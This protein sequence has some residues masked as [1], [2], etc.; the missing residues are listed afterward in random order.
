M[1][2]YESLQYEV[3]LEKDGFQIRKYKQF[4]TTAVKENTLRANN[5]FGI[6]F[7]YIS[8]NNKKRQ[9][10][11][12]TVPVISELDKDD[13]TMEFV[14]PAKFSKEQIPQPNDPSVKI[15]SYPEHTALVLEFTGSSR[16]KNVNENITKLMS[17]VKTNKFKTK[18]SVRVSQYSSPFSV[19]MF[20]KNE[21]SIEIDGTPYK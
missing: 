19:P 13:M 14:L 7:N 2:K 18:G 16:D 9:A 20:R 12:M 8:G 10:I 6:L 21:V 11:A 3:L 17:F 4:Y 15:K 1:A 5:G